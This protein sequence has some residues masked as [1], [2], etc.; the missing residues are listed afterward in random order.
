M[1]TNEILW[2]LKIAQK[3]GLATLGDLAKFKYYHRCK[4]NNE[5]LNAV[6]AV[7]CTEVK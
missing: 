4:T 1:N 6:N 7:Y 3:I 2:L 5:L